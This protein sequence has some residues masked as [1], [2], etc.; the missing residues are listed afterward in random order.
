MKFL[1]DTHVFIWAIASPERLSRRAIDVLRAT[2]NQLYLSSATP[3]ELATKFRIGKLP[4]AARVLDDLES[5]AGDLLAKQLPI[6]HAHAMRAGLLEA[7]HRDPF[8]R[9]LAAQAQLEGMRLITRDE[10][11]QALGVEVIW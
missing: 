7:A 9:M 1:L 6:T 10:A 5:L 11:F 2:G 4:Q 8:D 3:W